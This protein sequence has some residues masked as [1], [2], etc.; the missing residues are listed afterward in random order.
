MKKILIITLFTFLFLQ[1]CKDDDYPVE[2]IA[3]SAG[4]ITTAGS[5]WVYQWYDKDTSGN[6]TIKNIRDSI[7]VKG[8]TTI[9]NSVYTIYDGTYLGSQQI[10][11]YKD[12]MGYVV[13]SDGEILWNS[14]DTGVLKI[15]T[16]NQF[17]F[18]TRITDL[19]HAIQILGASYFAVKKTNTACRLDGGPV[20]E[21]NTCQSEMEYYVKDLGVVLA[22]TAYIGDC[23]RL[24]KRLVR[25]K[26]SE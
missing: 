17:S 18:T 2:I 16:S 3:P 25:Y 26:I 20:T 12:S 9:N 24:D 11:Y 21:C 15:E 23:N 6:E 4:L 13:N 7:Y 22:Q 10:N 14:I 8:D 5:Y 19:S 1:S